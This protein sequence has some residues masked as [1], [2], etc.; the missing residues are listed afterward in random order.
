MV[1]G[2]MGLVDRDH[3]ARV[4]T[5][6]REPEIFNR[7]ALGDRII[8]RDD[9]VEAFLAISAQND[10]AILLSLDGESFS[11]KGEG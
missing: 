11:L 10:P 5:I 3:T 1:D 6:A 7:R 2:D 9:V 8:D 4:R